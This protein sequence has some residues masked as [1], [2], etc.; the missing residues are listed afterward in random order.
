MDLVRKVNPVKITI[1]KR[2]PNNAL[3]SLIKLVVK[4]PKVEFNLRK[5][6]LL[7]KSKLAKYRTKNKKKSNVIITHEFS[8]NK[9]MAGFDW[10]DIKWRL[11]LLLLRYNIYRT[12]I[13]D[14]NVW[15][16]I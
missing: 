10:P 2:D 13:T 9:I 12:I 16:C 5:N 14:G 7:I 11:L 4:K 6:K 1:K 15:I 3:L 8:S